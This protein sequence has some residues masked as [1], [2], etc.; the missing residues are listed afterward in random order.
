MEFRLDD[1]HRNVRHTGFVAGYR[2]QEIRPQD[3]VNIRAAAQGVL[4]AR[5]AHPQASLADLCD[6]LTKPPNL[7][8]AHQALDTAVDAAYG[9]TGFRNDEERMAF[10]FE[11]HQRCT[12]LLPQPAAKPRRGRKKER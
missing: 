7:V 6:P 2:V 5:A 11:L 9:R 1:L 3:P 8:K 10:L 4:D 12:R